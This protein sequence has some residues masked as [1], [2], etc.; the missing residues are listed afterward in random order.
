MFENIIGHDI[1]KKI[2]CDELKNDRISHAYLF[3]GPKGIGKFKMAQEFAKYILNVGNLESCP[4][5]KCILKREDKKDIL[6][7]QIRKEVVDDVLLSP[8]SGNKK[9][10]VIDDAQY[11][12]VAAQNTLL[13]TL[14]EPPK[15]VVIILISNNLSSFLPTIISRIN[16]VN[17]NNISN[18]EVKNYIS[19]NY[20]TE[21]SSNIL[22]FVHGSIGNAVT[23]IENN[24]IDKLN[25][26]DTLFSHVKNKQAVEALNFVQN[27]KLNEY[28]IDYLEF[29]L[30]SNS[31]W[32]CV[33]FTQ[34]AKNRLKMNG[35]YDIVC[36]NMILNIIDNI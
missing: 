17:F 8:V 32:S 28:E 7:E 14:E 27:A 25:K 33:K 21:L 35:N 26:I 1:N 13:K 16:L 34:K 3:V 12:N 31:Y 29:L 11:L 6:V 2:L 10:Y 18:E 15:Y 24:M 20:K 9:V 5:Y 30:Y 36:D 4:D 23:I 22:Q 19:K